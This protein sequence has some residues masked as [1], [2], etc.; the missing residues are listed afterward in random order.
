MRLADPG[1]PQQQQS[2]AM[3]HPAAGSE[4]ADLPRIER[5]LSGKVKAVELAH[6]WEVGDLARHLD[7]PFILAGDLALDQKPQRLAQGQLTLGRLIQQTVELVAD[8]GQLEPAQRQ[9]QALVVEA[10]DQ[11]PPAACSYSASGRN[12]AAGGGALAAG[13]TALT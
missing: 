3:G 5:G 6:H 4:L 10:H 8:R 9:R 7:A 12:S 2:L 1:R 11:P 13:M